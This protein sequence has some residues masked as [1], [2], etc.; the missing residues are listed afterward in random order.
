MPETPQATISNTSQ[1]GMPSEMHTK[2]QTISKPVLVFGVVGILVGLL[3]IGYTMFLKPP[4]TPPIIQQPIQQPTPAELTLT[5][6]SPTDGTLVVENEILVQG[7]TNGTTI[8]IF[9]E[10]D[11]T[12]VESTFDGRFET[13]VQLSPGI[14]SLI[15]TAYSAEGQEKTITLNVVYDDEV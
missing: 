6:E 5:L 8:A 1:S 15:I 14:N 13:T 2:K 12:I 10:T 4:K 7:T 9:T 3:V 11:E